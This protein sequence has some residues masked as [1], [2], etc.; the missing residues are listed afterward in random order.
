MRSARRLAPGRR[1]APAATGAV[2]PV[3]RSDQR[4]RDRRPRRQPDGGS[5]PLARPGVPGAAAAASERGRAGTTRS[6]TPASRATPRRAASAALDWALDGDVRVLIVALGGNDGLRGLPPSELR[7]N[8]GADHRAGRRRAGSPSCWP[9][10]KRRPNYGRDYTAAFRKVYPDLA[11]TV[12]RDAAAV[13]ARRRRGPR[14]AE[15]AGRHSSDGRG[16]ADRRRPRL[17]RA[18]A[19]RGEAF[20]LMIDLRGVSKTVTSGTEPLTI[21]H[22]LTLH[23]ARGQFV[24]IVGPSGSGKS[25]LLGLIAGLDAPTTGD[26]LVDGVN[27]TTARRGRA[28][29]AARREDRVRL[30]VLPP[31]PVAHRLRERR[32]ADG[33]RGRRRSRA[34]GPSAC[35]TKSG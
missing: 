28:R 34:R 3:P 22:P 25:T 24:A 32:G 31:D 6:S 16:R 17:V 35:S 20:G 13:P 23:I 4:P 19:P 15:S 30:P 29:A 33:D 26:V 10:W 1:E 2:P 7:K 12:S 21:L 8:L 27:I 9:A 5:G 18:P 14:D 11:Q